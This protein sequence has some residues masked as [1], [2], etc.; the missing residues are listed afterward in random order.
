[1]PLLTYYCATN[2]AELSV[3][4]GR[5]R[6]GPLSDLDKIPPDSLKHLAA[7]EVFL[8]YTTGDFY[9]Y[10]Y[11]FIRDKEIRTKTSGGRRET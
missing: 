4:N 1:M 10:K 5:E 3:I 7:H 8:D 2:C 6:G 11:V 9:S